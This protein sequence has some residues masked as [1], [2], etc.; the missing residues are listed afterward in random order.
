MTFVYADSCFEKI[1]KSSTYILPKRSV[2]EDL[3][4]KN[5]EFHCKFSGFYW[6]FQFQL[7]L[8]CFFWVVD[9]YKMDMSFEDCSEYP[10]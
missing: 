5:E 7:D 2:A 10:S 1:K 3:S 8:F 6:K 4:W 9:G